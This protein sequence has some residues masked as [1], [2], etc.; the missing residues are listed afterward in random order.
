VL[1]VVLVEA[2]SKLFLGLFESWVWRFF[3]LVR[4]DAKADGKVKAQG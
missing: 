2:V 3:V 4:L 1:R